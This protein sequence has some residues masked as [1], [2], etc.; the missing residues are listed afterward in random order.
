VVR[1]VERSRLAPRR[2]V[3]SAPDHGPPV[4]LL[5]APAPG[6]RLAATFRSPGM[7]ARLQATTPRSKFPACCFLAALDCSE[8]RSADGSPTHDG[9]PPP[10]SG[11]LPPTRCFFPNQTLP[12]APWPLL[13]FRDLHP[14]RINAPASLPPESPPSENARLSL[15]PRRP[16]IGI[17][18]YGSTFRTRYAFGGLL[19]LKP[20]G[21]TLIMP[22]GGF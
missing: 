21:T 4:R 1:S 14:F 13:P 5:T 15:A 6:L 3:S 20:L 11:S 10:W 17:V 19:F 16:S 9:L 12:I 18:G 8:A 7:T 22:P 2:L